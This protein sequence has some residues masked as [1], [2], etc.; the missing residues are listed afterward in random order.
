MTRTANLAN[1]TINT[2]GVA[3]SAAITYGTGAFIL[4]LPANTSTYAYI[5][6]ALTLQQFPLYLDFLALFQYYKVVGFKVMIV[7]WYTTY[8]GAQSIAAIPGSEMIVHSIID[9]NGGAITADET[10]LDLMRQQKS[11]KVQRVAASNR[12][13]QR[14]VKAPK[15]LS[16]NEFVGGASALTSRSSGW[17]TTAGNGTLVPHYGVK[18]LIEQTNPNAAVILGNL[19]KVYSKVYLQLRDPQ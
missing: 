2:L 13:F 10:G 19:F 8:L 12:I 4:T 7:P 1:L 14:Y 15:L 6:Y 17:T 11:Y 18:I 16:E 9:Y 5:T 3:V